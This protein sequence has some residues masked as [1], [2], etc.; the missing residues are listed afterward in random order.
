MEVRKIDLAPETGVLVELRLKAQDQ[1]DKAPRSEIM[2]TRGGLTI[3]R[4]WMGNRC[5][6]LANE[7]LLF[8]Q[9]V[10]VRGSF[11]H[12]TIDEWMSRGNIRFCGY[13]FQYSSENFYITECKMTKWNTSVLKHK[14]F[15]SC[16]EGL[17]EH[18]YKKMVQAGWLQ[19]EWHLT[20]VH[21]C[22]SA[23]WYSIA[24]SGSNFV[25]RKRT[26]L[27][28]WVSKSLR[29][30]KRIYWKHFDGVKF[31]FL[32]FCVLTAWQFVG[33]VGIYVYANGLMI[34]QLILLWPEVMW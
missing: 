4:A 26:S 23:L 12:P 10:P 25:L 24:S 16:K 13:I 2:E 15:A 33:A 8:C 14:R 30:L 31:S 20:L 34:L 3:G 6:R 17:K 32:S 21:R 19:P 29:M 27:G 1:K 5:Y 9:P 7:A 11:T 22:F 28:Y 18:L